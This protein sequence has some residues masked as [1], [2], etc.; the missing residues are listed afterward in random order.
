MCGLTVWFWPSDP[1]DQGTS[2]TRHRAMDDYDFLTWTARSQR[3]PKFWPSQNYPNSVRIYLSLPPQTAVAPVALRHRRPRIVEKSD[4]GHPPM[5]S[6]N[7]I[8]AVC[9]GT[10]YNPGELCGETE[11]AGQRFCPAS[12]TEARVAVGGRWDSDRVPASRDVFHLVDTRKPAAF[13]FLGGAKGV[14]RPM[15]WPSA[16]GSRVG[17]SGIRSRSRAATPTLS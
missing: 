4:G 5:P 10:I 2:L 13:G 3:A 11:G 6:Q 15:P 17:L 12:D 8:C 7:G 14:H 1:L 16:I 9:N